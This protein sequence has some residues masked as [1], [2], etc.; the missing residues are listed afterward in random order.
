M[1]GALDGIRIVD[2]STVVLGP[3][4]SQMLGDM[5][6]DVI[7]VETPAGD[8]TRNIGQGRNPKMASL[9]WPLTVINA[10]WY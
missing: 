5:G 6:A 1:A 4:T 3:W 9:S 7:K 8:L 10:A 2:P